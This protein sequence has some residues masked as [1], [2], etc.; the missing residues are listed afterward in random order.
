MLFSRSLFRGA[1][2]TTNEQRTITPSVCLRLSV[3]GRAEALPATGFQGGRLGGDFPASASPL[4][5]SEMV[6]CLQDL[7]IKNPAHRF[8]RAGLGKI[9]WYL[10]LGCDVLHPAGSGPK[11]L[12]FITQTIFER[13]VNQHS[14]ITRP[15][16]GYRI[17]MLS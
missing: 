15:Q 6:G 1:V 16:G 11:R 10:F 17:Q 8:R 7:Q 2:K 5:C 13:G 12:L 9:A 4:R 3:T 14:G